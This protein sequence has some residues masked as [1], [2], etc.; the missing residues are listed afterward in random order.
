MMNPATRS[1][2][3]LNPFTRIISEGEGK[4]LV[5][6][7]NGTMVMPKFFPAEDETCSDSFMTEDINYCWNLDGTS[8]TSRDYDMM[9]TVDVQIFLDEWFS[10]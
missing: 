6:L 1:Q 2:D 7:R 8:V 10:S 5:K 9:E 3:E 4:F